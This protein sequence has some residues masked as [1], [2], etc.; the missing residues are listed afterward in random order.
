MA[1]MCTRGFG[2]CDA[3]GCCRDWDEDENETFR[4]EDEQDEEDE[5]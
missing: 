4:D 3:C 2:E 5:D 1:Y